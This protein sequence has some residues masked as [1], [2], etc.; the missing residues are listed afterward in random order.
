MSLTERGMEPYLPKLSTFQ[1]FSVTLYK[2]RKVKPF[3][4]N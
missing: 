4:N 2:T 1:E 3:C